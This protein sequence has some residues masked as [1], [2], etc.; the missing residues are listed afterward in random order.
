M[1]TMSGGVPVREERFR[2]QV[3]LLAATRKDGHVATANDTRNSFTYKTGIGWT[4]LVPMDG[5]AGQPLVAA[6]DRGISS[7]DTHNRLVP[8]GGV[9]GQVA[10][11]DQ[12]G[13]TQLGYRY[14]QGTVAYP[15]DFSSGS[16]TLCLDRVIPAGALG[17]TGFLR[18]TA[19]II[20]TTNA[21]RTVTF[22]MTSGP[23]V[24]PLDTTSL[25][26]NVNHWGI[27]YTMLM[28]N[29]GSETSNVCSSRIMWALWTDSTSTSSSEDF[30]MQVGQGGNLDTTA[31]WELSAQVQASG[32]VT[33]EA[34]VRG[35]AVEYGYGA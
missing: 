31:D 26:S 16:I 34:A 2:T 9:A 17:P 11:V 21:A 24:N 33:G 22:S 12:F 32:A 27:E 15:V 20:M 30:Q 23:S 28:L 19:A 18:V 29:Q 14:A 25:G 8:A 7:F 1:L 6:Q 10:Q 35:V 4:P 5:L 13:E 3:Q